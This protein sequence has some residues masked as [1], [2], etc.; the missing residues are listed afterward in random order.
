M[1]HTI[2]RGRGARMT[3]AVAAAGALSLL[4]ACGG[5]SDAT[6]TT[7]SASASAAATASGNKT[8][9]F[10]PLALK[11]PAMKG[12]SE[13][14]KGYGGSKGYEVV[15]QDP[16]LDPQKQATQLQQVIESGK[17]GGAWAIAVQPGALKE[18]VRIAQEKKIPLV[19]NGVPA[20]YGLSGLVPGVSF[21]TIDYAAQGK[22]IGD[23]LGKCINEKSGGK[24]KVLWIE[25]SAGTAGKA[26]L[27]G[28]AKEALLAT[29]P[30]ATIATTITVTDRAATQT[31]V[32]NALQGN[33][34][35][36]AVMGQNDEGALGALGAFAAAGKD[37]TC[38]TEAG[39]NDEALAAA[40]SGKIYAVV[41]LQ[42]QDDMAQSFDT[43][44]KM[45][46]DPAMTGLQLTVPQ[47]VV[48]AAG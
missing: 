18:V 37:L 9:I 2:T 28:A 19:L 20:D 32:G 4:T 7:S 29:A 30:G 14:V 25:S 46:A 10:S 34:D 42:F 43:L 24:A 23:E 12:L 5:G 44:T 27:E 1:T 39:G 6:D 48:T 17:A 36:T 45:M 38:L 11:I 13:G 16:N 41:A 33:P 8:I 31:A 22:A 21:S 15:V 26:E 40:K 35:V 47:K 3:A